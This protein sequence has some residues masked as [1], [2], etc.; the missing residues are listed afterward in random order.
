MFVLPELKVR[1]KIPAYFKPGADLEYVK[2][3]KRLT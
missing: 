2:S 3:V 1:E